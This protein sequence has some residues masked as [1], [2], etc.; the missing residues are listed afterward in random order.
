M[1]ES[2]KKERETKRGIQSVQEKLKNTEDGQERSNIW[3][4]SI[5][6]EENK[7]K[8]REQIKKKT[9]IQKHFCETYFKF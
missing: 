3:I 5:L 6:K 2:L 7:G 1:E 9:I 4:V 8:G